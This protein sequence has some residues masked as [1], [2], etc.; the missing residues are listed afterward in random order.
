MRRQKCFVVEHR[1]GGVTTTVTSFRPYH[2]E[3]SDAKLRILEAANSGEPLTLCVVEHVNSK[4]FSTDGHGDV[5]AR[6]SM[7]V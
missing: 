2:T 6:G 1:A 4:T 5:K 7:L 3:V